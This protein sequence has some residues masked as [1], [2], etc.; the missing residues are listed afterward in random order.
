MTNKR[1]YNGP[2]RPITAAKA[3]HKVKA[4]LNAPVAVDPRVLIVNELPSE[5][6]IIKSTP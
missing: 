1:I 3:T 2:A 4:N 6:Y 5:T